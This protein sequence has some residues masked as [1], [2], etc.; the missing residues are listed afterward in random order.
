MGF[1]LLSGFGWIFYEGYN[2]LNQKSFIQIQLV[3]DLQQVENTV[4][5]VIVH[6]DSLVKTC[7][8]HTLVTKDF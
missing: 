2:K 1:V 7:L 4:E 3:Q 8:K 5:N 6:W